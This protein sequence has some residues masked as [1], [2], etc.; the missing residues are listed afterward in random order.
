MPRKSELNFK[1]ILGLSISFLFAE[2]YSNFQVF[3]VKEWKQIMKFRLII[4]LVH[5][6]NV[7]NANALVLSKLLTKSLKALIENI[8]LIKCMHENF[9]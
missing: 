7:L 3:F 2:Q 8:F 4:R 9:F 1:I 5:K 6:L